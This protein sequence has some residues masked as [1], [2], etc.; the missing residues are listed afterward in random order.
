MRRRGITT[1]NG[2]SPRAAAPVPA[3]PAKRAAKRGFFPT[4]SEPGKGRGR[5]GPAE[6]AAEGPAAAEAAT[7]PPRE[8]GPGERGGEGADRPRGE[9]SRGLSP[10]EICA[11]CAC[12]GRGGHTDSVPVEAGSQAGLRLQGVRYLSRL[13]DGRREDSCV[14]REQGDDVLSLVAELK[15]EAERLRSIREREEERDWWNHAQTSL[16]EKPQ[17]PRKPKIKEILCPPPARLKAVAKW[18]AVN[19]GKSLLG[20]AR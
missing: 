5:A 9:L 2:H 6:G 13:T 11:L 7:A 18:R 3:R 19:G 12:Q 20:A 4:F 17:Q 8:G 14:R 10:A 1:T 16:R 15:E